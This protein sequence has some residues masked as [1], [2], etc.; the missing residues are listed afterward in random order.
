MPTAST[1]TWDQNQVFNYAPEGGC[2]DQFEIESGQFV[3][4][5]A[6][7]PPTSE[8]ALK[9]W[10]PVA[11]VKVH[12]EYRRKVVNFKLQ[13]NGTPPKA[14]SPKNT[15]AMVFIG[16]TLAFPTPQLDSTLSNFNWRT[17][18]QY[19]FIEN[20]R[21]SVDDGFL[22]TGR[23]FTLQTQA[24]FRQFLG[25]TSQIKYGAIAQAG[26]DAQTGYLI[27]QIATQQGSL[28]LP[29]FSYTIPTFV[30]ALF[31]SSDVLNGHAPIPYTT[32][33]VS[34]PPLL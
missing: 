7:D 17:L 18:G 24:D 4:P 8:E 23:P 34:G 21:S 25:D 29:D 26:D 15:G 10:S 30:P 1:E 28:T 11:V 19:E 31:F 13:K 27:G 32:E 20:C 6:E 5:L 2:I 14:P 9:T 16:G 12:A 33:L 22:L 3:I